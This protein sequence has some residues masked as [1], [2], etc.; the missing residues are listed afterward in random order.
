MTKVSQA[1]VL[2]AGRGERLHPLTSLRP[3]VLL[4]VANK[5]ILRYVL[6]ALA[7][8]GIGDIVVVVGYRRERVQ[9][10][11]GS[12]DELGVRIR[13]VVQ[14]QQLGTGDALRGALKL[15]GPQFLVLPG[16]NMIAPETI[17]PLLEAQGETILVKEEGSPYH[18]GLVVAEDGR[19]VRLV[20]KPGLPLSRW[21]NTGNYLLTSRIFSYLEEHQDLTAAIQHM[22][23]DQQSV[24]IQNTTGPWLDANY[25]WDLLELNNVALGKLSPMP[26]PQR[27][28]GVVIKGPVNV[29]KN[30]IIRA[31]SYLVGPLLIGSGSEIGPNA[32]VFPSTTV[33]DNV[34]IGPFTEVRNS[35]IEDS[36][37]I[38]AHSLVQD[39]LIAGGCTFEGRLAIAS[40]RITIPDGEGRV[41]RA[42][43]VIADYAEV[44]YDVTFASG[45]MVGKGVHVR[46]G[47]RIAENI[48]EDALVL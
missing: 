5:P 13:Y 2:A 19:V 3:K 46:G 10:A 21:V 36:V 35:I 41:V 26:T 11:L 8:N 25:P 43:A 30:T 24:R 44:G 39:S 9:D 17:A 48:P 32:C 20:E 40:G 12:G 6:E 33:G 22:V 42:G 37:R 1:V 31:N 16:D 34:V 47:K 23:D 4:P 27:E 15:A 38:G 45:I 18:Y 14:E 28:E 7:A 29:G